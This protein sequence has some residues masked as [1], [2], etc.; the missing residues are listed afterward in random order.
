MSPSPP[1]ILARFDERPRLALRPGGEL[2]GLFVRWRAGSQEIAARRSAD[3]GRTWTEPQT[4]LVLPSEP[5]HW[6]GCQ[7]VADLDGELHAF[8][9]NDR[10][11]GVFPDA[12]GQREAG[13]QVPRR[14]DIWHTR[15]AGDIQAWRGPQRIW[16]G[17]TG[18]L[19]GGLCTRAGRL[20]LPFA[21]LTSRTWRERGEGLDAFWFS[22]TSSSLAVYSDDGGDT[23]QESPSELKVQS[24]AIGTYGA[25]EP[26]VAEL[27]D[28]RLW[29]LIRTQLGRFYD[30]ISADGARWS[31]PRP[32]HLINSDSPAGLVRVPDGRLVLLWNKCRRFPYAHGGRHVLHGA[33]SSDEGRTWVGHREVARDP[34][35]DEPPPAGG[36]HGTAYPYPLALPDGAVLATTGQGA[37][38]VCIVRID[39]EWLAAGESRWPGAGDDGDAWS[40][41]GCRGASL[42]GGAGGQARL[43]VARAAAEWPAAAVWNFPLARR[44]ALHLRL[45]ARAPFGGAL[46]LLADHFSVPFDPEDAID[47]VVATQLVAAGAASA[48]PGDGFDDGDT[49]GPRAMG[50]RWLPEAVG[51]LALPAGEWC[52]VTVEWDLDAARVRLSGPGGPAV[53]LRPRRVAD[54]LCYL[55]LK[56]TAESADGGL[57]LESV[58]SE[59]RPPLGEE[60]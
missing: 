60:I 30:S 6:G 50:P 40:T 45:R 16:Q 8:L 23:W 46:L 59:R 41:F 1:E 19:N 43:C 56:S 21:R 47:A 42:A 52:D 3:G 22:G 53:D 49:P 35:R 34:L 54:G 57:E 2:V 36:D 25:V 51:S 26:V 10:H 28:G 13:P 15:T 27:E 38:R 7:V 48:A 44:G 11:T 32:T 39:P 14:I 9:L 18:S 55:R 31:Q 29:M 33:V 12:G 4:L 20:V 24:P 5:G 37:G 58:R 17:Y